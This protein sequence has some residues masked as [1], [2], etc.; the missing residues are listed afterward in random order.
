MLDNCALLFY[1]LIVLVHALTLLVSRECIVG[2]LV[3]EDYEG[4][5]DVDSV[6][7]LCHRRIMP[8]R[9]YRAKY[10]GQANDEEEVINY[11]KLIGKS[12]SQRML[13]YR[14]P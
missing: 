12:C 7:V 14:D 9:M 2:W 5:V 3:A 4:K 11:A 13:L 1:V 10:K 8:Y 6:T